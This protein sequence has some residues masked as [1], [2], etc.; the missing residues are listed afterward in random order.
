MAALDS[1]ERFPIWQR[2]VTF[3]L[4]AAAIVGIWFYFFYAESVT[5]HDG[6]I[7]ARDKAN[8]EFKRVTE[9]KEKFLERQRKQK[10]VEDEL[11]ASME[12]LPMSSSAVDNLMQTFQQQARLV[13]LTVET[14]TPGAEEKLDYYA[15]MPVKVKAS[16]T[17][18]QTG[19]FF[20][21]VSEL[22]RPVSIEGI[23]LAMRD[24]RGGKESAD[25]GAPP[26]LDVE[27]EVTTY[28]F[29]PEEERRAEAAGGGKRKAASRRKK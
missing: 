12:V 2:L 13:G 21:R 8:A 1:F 17:W 26:V 4:V 23:K 9:E 15:R 29:L 14:W 27:F 25:A 18:A 24:G 3:I 11:K 6:A 19:E 20:R 16:G 10:E 22:N 7:A 5:S 28:R